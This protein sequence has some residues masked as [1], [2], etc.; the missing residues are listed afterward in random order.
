MLAII[1]GGGQVGAYLARLLLAEQHQVKIV[2]RRRERVAVLQQLLP[3]ELVVGGSGSD[4]FVLEAAGVRNASVVAA[5]TGADET[6]LVVCCLA[7]LEFKVPRVIARVN[8]PNNAWLYRPEMGVDVALNQT[9]LLAHLVAE[10]MSL[11]E[12]MTLLKLRR[13]MY[14][15]VEE[16]VHPNSAAA[17]ET[18]AELSLPR[19]SVLVAIMRGGEIHVP[20]RHTVLQAEDEVIALVHRGDAAQL[21]ALLDAQ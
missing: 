11:G 15:L 9:D 20:H 6:N 19:R 8:N 2:E 1:V 17:G 10:E 5:V 4:P 3:P 21:A 13:G 12:M 16:K 7:R 18:L 14:S